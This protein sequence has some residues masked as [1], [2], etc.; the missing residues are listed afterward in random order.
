MSI[1][2]SSQTSRGPCRGVDGALAERVLPN[3]RTV[4][5][6]DSSGVRSQG[7]CLPEGELAVQP[8]P[9]GHSRPGSPE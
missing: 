6:N 1:V 8:Q 9:W 4:G 2:V 7:A 5:S 3:L